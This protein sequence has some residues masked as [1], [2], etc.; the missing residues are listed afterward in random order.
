MVLLET[1]DLI[2]V[3]G[4]KVLDLIKVLKA[5]MLDPTLVHL[6]A[7]DLIQVLVP[8]QTDLDLTRVHLKDKAIRALEVQVVHRKVEAEILDQMEDHQVMVK[9]EAHLLGLQEIQ[10]DQDQDQDR[11]IQDQMKI[12][13]LLKSLNQK[14]E[15]K[16]TS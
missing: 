15:E 4:H 13:L 12:L 10:T 2:K 7:P 14:V 6:K 1:P 8:D 3:Q 16:L 5:Q 11:E 9:L